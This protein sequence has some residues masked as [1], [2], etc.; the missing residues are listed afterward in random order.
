MKEMMS[1]GLRCDDAES[2]PY[3]FTISIVSTLE[4]YMHKYERIKIDPY[5]TLTPSG[6]M[7]RNA[8]RFKAPSPPLHDMFSMPFDHIA[9][10]LDNQYP[11]R[12]DKTQC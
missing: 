9:E 10:L 1:L 7:Y 8:L 11:M 2:E 4:L 6:Y 3:R 12:L 5:R